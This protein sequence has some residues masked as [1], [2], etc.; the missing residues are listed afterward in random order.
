MEKKQALS[1][2][3]ALCA[4]QEYCEA[5]VRSKLR[6]WGAQSSDIDEI[7]SELIKESFIDDLRYAV[8]YASDKVRLN[9]WG[10]VKIRYMLSA[11]KI[12]GQTINKAFEEIDEEVY[13][14]TLRELLV[15]KERTLRSEKD[16]W[17]K[18]QKLIRFA[19]GHGFE[20]D[21][22]IKILNGLMS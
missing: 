17:T 21:E 14:E 7:I 19:L 8:S 13:S 9:Q 2:A 16:A 11:K 12:S 18:R 5:D 22:I 20:T 15:K 4:G 10:R 1:K 3:M 6:G